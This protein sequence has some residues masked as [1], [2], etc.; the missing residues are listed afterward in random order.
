MEL[1]QPIKVKIPYIPRNMK[2]N[3]PS[4]E[5]QANIERIQKQRQYFQKLNRV[6]DDN[7]QLMYPFK[8]GN[9]KIPK[10]PH[11]SDHKYTLQKKKLSKPNFSNTPGCWE[12]DILVTKD[13][14]R[15]LQLYLVMINVNTRYLIVTP[16]ASKSAQ[17]IIPPL[18][19]SRDKLIMTFN[20]PINTIKSDGEKSFPSA[21]QSVFGDSVKHIIDT[22]PYTYH[23]K[24]VDAAIRTLRN[25]LGENNQVLISNP[26]IMEQLVWHYNNNKVHKFTQITPTEFMNNPDAEYI[27]ISMMQTELNKIKSRERLQ[28]RP[29]PGSIVMAHLPSAKTSDRFA[30]R[31]RDYHT[32]AYLIK[33]QGS[34]AIIQR[35]TAEPNPD[36]SVEQLRVPTFAIQFVCNTLRDIYDEHGLTSL[37]EQIKHTFNLKITSQ[38]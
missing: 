20:Y 38:N 14:D 24:T 18:T 16:I 11:L 6:L 33:Y 35:L 37:G 31:R 15:E 19:Q 1:P 26:D 23:N 5:F 36:G 30:K 13:I 7:E 22:S 10:K 27:Y 12:M 32:L 21:I 17:S 28:P 8:T 29:Q 25:A 9:D 3:Q 2:L 4:Q 34:S